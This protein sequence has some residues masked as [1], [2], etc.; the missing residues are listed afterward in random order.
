MKS[1]RSKKLRKFQDELQQV[2]SRVDD[3][4]VLSPKEKQVINQ[5][6]ERSL[7]IKDAQKILKH[8]G[9]PKEFVENLSQ[10]FKNCEQRDFFDCALEENCDWDTSSDKCVQKQEE[11]FDFEYIPLP[12]LYEIMLNLDRKELHYLC[13]SNKVANKICKEPRFREDYNK[14]HPRKMK[15]TILLVNIPYDTDDY[16]SQADFDFVSAMDQKYPDFRQYLTAGDIIENLPHSGYR[17]DGVYMYDGKHIIDINR[18]KDPYGSV[19][20]K[21]KVFK[22][23]PPDYWSPW[24][25]MTVDD[26]YEP[27]EKSKAYWHYDSLPL[28]DKNIFTGLEMTKT[29]D[30][31][32]LYVDITFLGKTYRVFVKNKYLLKPKK[33][34]VSYIKENNGI[35]EVF[36]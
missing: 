24:E 16:D 9:S 7:T 19:S 30:G 34:Y 10:S 1:T 2:Q 14:R 25:S 35:S 3:L 17:S 28:I 22:D 15:A 23:F 18:Y 8:S 26:R 33:L 5:E 13:T 6:V 32:R 36:T 4:S 21:F 31:K 20:T 12:A 29:D 11:K 27:G